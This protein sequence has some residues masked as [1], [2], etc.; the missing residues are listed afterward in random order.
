MRQTFQPEQLAWIGTRFLDPIGRVFKYEDAYFRA[1]YPDKKEYVEQLFSLGIVER[2]DQNGWLVQMERADISVAGYALV[3]R[4]SAAPFDVRGHEYSRSMLREAAL[5]W[6]DMNLLLWQ[7]NMGLMDAHPGNFQVFGACRPTWVDLGSIVPIGNDPA[8]GLHEFMKNFVFPLVL[9]GK[10]NQ[11]SRVA[12]LLIKDGGVSAEEF[13]DLCGHSLPIV[14]SR[15]QILHGLR[16]L[17]EGLAFAHGCSTWGDYGNDRLNGVDYSGAFKP[18]P[19][20]RASKILELIEEANP[21][22]ILDLGANDGFF[23]ARAA[24]RG[25]EVL[26]VDSDEEALERFYA[27]LKKSPVP[28]SA[29]ISVEDVVYCRKQADLVLALALTHH[30]SLSQKF[31]FDFI[32]KHLADRTRRTLILEYMPNGLGVG[33]KVVPDPLPPFYSLECCL[34][35]LRKHFFR[36]G[37]VNYD[38]PADVSPRTLIRCERCAD[39]T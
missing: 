36:V 16:D 38:R 14:G 19:D 8:Q 35:E 22:T 39:A 13:R 1:V 15:P 28:L 37:V 31:K 20:P 34:H 11:L 9:I 29:S 12:R 2:L 6:L 17:V 10:S 21:K 18:S 30:L 24:A 33:G 27:W 26:A 32:A 7:W 4:A 5:A 25:Y 23:S 3:L